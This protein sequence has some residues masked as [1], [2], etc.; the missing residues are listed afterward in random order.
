MNIGGLNLL[1]CRDFIPTLPDGFRYLT[2]ADQLRFL[3]SNPGLYKYHFIK[4]YHQYIHLSITSPEFQKIR[5]YFEKTINLPY[6][7]PVPRTF[8]EFLVYG[9]EKIPV[10]WRKYV[11]DKNFYQILEKFYRI[12][13]TM[14]LKI[15]EMFRLELDSNQ[16]NTFVDSEVDFTGKTINLTNLDYLMV[17]TEEYIRTELYKIIQIDANV[18]LI[19]DNYERYSAHKVMLQQLLFDNKLKRMEEENFND[20]LIHTGKIPKRGLPAF[21]KYNLNLVRSIEKAKLG[22]VV[23]DDCKSK[24]RYMELNLGDI[25]NRIGLQIPKREFI[26]VVYNRLLPKT[27]KEIEKF[28]VNHIDDLYTLRY[29]ICTEYFEDE[30]KLDDDEQILWDAFEDVCQVTHLEEDLLRS[31]LLGKR[32]KEYYQTKSIKEPTLNFEILVSRV[33]KKKNISKK[34]M[35]NGVHWIG[36]KLL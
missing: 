7:F 26:V 23:Y 15:I 13:N 24:C 18:T 19:E 2:F 17:R 28:T 1:A 25:R 11:G 33:L 12:N 6:H 9:N 20:Q 32:L 30:N 8:E 21:V 29:F 35:H 27:I 5:L 36:I 3:E 14:A 22:V 34:R 10:S 31:G 16:I 4:H